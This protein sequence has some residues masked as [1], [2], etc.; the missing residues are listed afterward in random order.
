MLVGDGP[1]RLELESEAEKL[2]IRDQIL[3]FGD[4]RDIPAV[5]ASLDLSV[6][7]SSSESL[8]NAIIESMAAGVP[9]VA[10]RV[11][12]NPELVTETRGALVPPND[13]QSLADAI[14]RILRDGP[15]RND[16]GR[17]AKQFAQA[18]FTIDNMRRRHEELYT[19]LLEKKHWRSKSIAVGSV[20]PGKRRLLH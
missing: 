4:R 1:L 10:S 11:G 19:A 12:G 9:V 16:I 15:L 14:E 5:L 8:S 18:N 3:F 6:L 13:V 2:G 20:H 17:N 7:P